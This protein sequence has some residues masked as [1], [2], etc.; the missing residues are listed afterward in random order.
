MTVGAGS[1]HPIELEDLVTAGAGH[2]GVALPQWKARLRVIE[3]DRIEQRSPPFR[4]VALTAIS[5]HLPV[6]VIDIL[7]SGGQMGT[8]Q[9]EA[10]G[11]RQGQTQPTTQRIP[12]SI[13]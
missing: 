6:R 12:V 9:Q 1:S 2:A 4:G 7:L 8:S 3:F 11:Q 10:R 13:R 5:I